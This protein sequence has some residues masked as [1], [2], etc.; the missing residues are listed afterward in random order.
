MLPL[1]TFISFFYLLIKTVFAD[2]FVIQEFCRNRDM[3]HLFGG[4]DYTIDSYAVHYDGNVLQVG[5]YVTQDSG[6]VHSFWYA[7]N[8]FTCGLQ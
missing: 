6:F 2:S 1:V 3:Y 7:I 5:G 8:P 4:K